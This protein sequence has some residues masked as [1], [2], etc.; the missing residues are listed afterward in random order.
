VQTILSSPL[1]GAGAVGTMYLTALQSARR[2][3]LIAN[4]YFVPDARVVEVLL[5]ARQRGVRVTL[6]LTGP[7]TDVWWARQTSVRHY[8]QLLEAGIE[9]Y[10]FQPALLHQKTM[11]VDGTWATVGT[12][13]L[14][15]R[16]FALNEETNLCFHDRQVAKTLKAIFDADLSRSAPVRLEAWRRRGV[17]QRLNEEMASLIEDQL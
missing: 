1:S 8:G 10:E 9:I 5:A 4:P 13:N 12:A 6:M 2:E 3:V 14:D 7:H 11:M 17:R 15:N 16:S